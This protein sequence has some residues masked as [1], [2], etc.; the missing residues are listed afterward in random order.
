[1]LSVLTA[2]SVV[3]FCGFYC[4]QISVPGLFRDRY[5]AL[6]DVLA[7]RKTE[8]TLWLEE[9]LNPSYRA[10][11]ERR[12]GAWEYES[13][14]CFLETWYNSALNTPIENWKEM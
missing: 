12:D 1:M 9:N 2:Y 8:A 11:T 13:Y 6:K 10:E 14:L 4:I 3:W 7:V 5:Q